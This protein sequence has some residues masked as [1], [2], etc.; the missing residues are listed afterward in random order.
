MEERIK[1]IIDNTASRA[2]ASFAKHAKAIIPLFIIAGSAIAHS[3]GLP[4]HLGMSASE[5]YVTGLKQF[6]CT[7]PDSE[8]TLKPKLK[9]FRFATVDFFGVKGCMAAMFNDREVVRSVIFSTAK[10]SWVDES[11]QKYHGWEEDYVQSDIIELEK[12]ISEKLGKSK[13]KGS[14]YSWNVGS[15]TCKL[16]LYQDNIYYSE[17]NSKTK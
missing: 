17:S 2:L 7:V 3:Q 10:P 12:R 15:S 5:V 9:S 6:E 1:T 11:C 4:I 16:Y 13:K 8:G 14:E